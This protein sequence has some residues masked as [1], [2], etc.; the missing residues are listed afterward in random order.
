[1][2]VG[3][4]GAIFCKIKAMHIINVAVA[5]IVNF[6]KAF[7]SASFIEARLARILPKKILKSL[8]LQVEAGVDDCNDYRFARADIILTV[9]MKG[10]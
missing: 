7:V 2:S 10:K 5:I 1:V 3:E 4:G 8:I 6:V 9:S